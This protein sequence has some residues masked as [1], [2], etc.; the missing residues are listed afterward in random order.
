MMVDRLGLQEHGL[1]D[2]SIRKS[3]HRQPGHLL[4]F[5]GQLAG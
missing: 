1:G 3:L 2:L 5:G 4:F